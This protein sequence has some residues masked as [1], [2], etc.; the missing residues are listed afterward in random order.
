M[1]PLIFYFSWIEKKI[2]LVTCN[3]VHEVTRDV[4]WAESNFH[5]FHV[6]MDI[7]ASEAVP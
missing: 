5:C 6:Q 1:L 7:G 4:H 2:Y 3:S